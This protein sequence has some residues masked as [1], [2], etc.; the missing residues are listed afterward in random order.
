MDDLQKYINRFDAL[1]RKVRRKGKAN[2]LEILKKTSFFSVPAST[3]GPFA[4]EGGLLKHSLAV[5]DCLL[6]KKETPFGKETL[7]YLPEESLIIMGLLHDHRNH[8]LFTLK[9]GP[10]DI[11]SDIVEISENEYYILNKS[12]PFCLE[13]YSAHSLY[14]DMTIAPHEYFAIRYHK[15]IDLFQNQYSFFKSNDDKWTFVLGIILALH[16]ADLETEFIYN[17]PED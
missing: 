4:C 5:Y 2:F 13:E 10:I 6:A 17:S 16:E 12:G 9:K 8:L 11:D 1:M 7:G 3:Y 14:R 15:D